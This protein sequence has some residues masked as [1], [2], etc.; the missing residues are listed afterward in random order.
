MSASACDLLCIAPHTDDAEIALGGWLHALGQRGH[1]V[2]VCDLTAGELASNAT[3][4]ERWSEALAASEVLGLAGRVQLGLPDG[5]LA[6]DQPGQAGAVVHVLRTLRPRWVV[7]APEPRRHPDHLATPPL[8]RRAVFLARLRTL[9]PAPPPGRWWPRPPAGA[10]EE[11]TTPWVVQVLAET[12]GRDQAPDLLL[13]VS[14]SWPAKREALACYGSQF[15]R[16][17][18][19]A[20]T[21]I[22]DPG[23]LDDIDARGRAW[24]CRAG[25]ERAEALRVDGA[26]VVQDLP[27]ERRA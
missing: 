22:N 11:A 3:P 1:R 17:A 16:E 15:R 20:P 5:F 4:T 8:V 19:R 12:C 10:S 18:G 23:F 26:P 14:A 25:V 2:W 9:Q 7:T 24:G 27:A 21:A 6:A 13:D